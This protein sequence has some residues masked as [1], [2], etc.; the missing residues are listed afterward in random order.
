MSET[1][2]VYEVMLRYQATDELIVDVRKDIE[3]LDGEPITEEYVEGFSY[4]ESC[5][6]EN[7]YRDAL[8]QFK[9]LLVKYREL[10]E[11]EDNSSVNEW[12]EVEH[13]ARK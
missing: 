10:A 12:D 3:R 1:K 8:K 11:K 2:T 9:K 5:N 7:N 6:I 4:E 13:D